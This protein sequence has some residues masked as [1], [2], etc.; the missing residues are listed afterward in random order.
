MATVADLITSALRELGIVAVTDTPGADLS[1]L[2][3]AQLNRVL[4]RWNADRRAVYADVHTSPVALTAGV[5][6]HTIGLAADVPH[7]TVTTNRPV[8]V[9]GV[10]L[11]TDNGESYLAPLTKRDAA[12]WHDLASP[13]TAGA[14]PTDFYYNP[15]MPVGSLYLWPEPSSTAVKVQLWYRVVLSQVATSDTLS[16]P[17]GYHD[18]LHAT[19]KERL[20]ALPM[21]ASMAS[22]GI[23]DEAR[24]ARAAAFGNNEPISGMATADIGIGAA[25]RSYRVELGPFS[26]MG[27]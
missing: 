6:P 24:A 18:A 26:M 17:P 25:G 11:T 12:W 22:P 23:A 27:H 10:R 20:A 14:Y 1:A 3:L 5:N 19:L 13:G 2:A 7:L 21:F 9:E 4:D 15:A 16:L 8:S